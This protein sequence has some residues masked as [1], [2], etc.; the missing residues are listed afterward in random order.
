MFS[1]DFSCSKLLF[2]GSTLA[3]TQPHPW[4][5]VR[6]CALPKKCQPPWF[7]QNRSADSTAAA[8]NVQKLW[9]CTVTK[10]IIRFTPNFVNGGDLS[11]SICG[12]KLIPFRLAVSEL[13]G[14]SKVKYPYCTSFACRAEPRLSP[15]IFS[16]K[17][18]NHALDHMQEEFPAK[19]G[20]CMIAWSISHFNSQWE[21]W[22]KLSF[23][24]C[25]FTLLFCFE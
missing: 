10:P 15:K 22:L 1:A 8:Q 7:G 20:Y 23:E 12:S 5:W 2:E 14:G 9:T 21:V 24:N 17:I 13:E 25:A 19:I 3:I 11:S 6:S 4:F 18:H 16:M